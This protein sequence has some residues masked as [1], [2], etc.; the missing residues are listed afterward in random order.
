MRRAAKLPDG[1]FYCLNCFKAA[2]PS[3]R[4]KPGTIKFCSPACRKEFWRY[5]GVSVHRLRIHVQGWIREALPEILAPLLEAE[6]RRLIPELV[7]E[8]KKK[9]L[10]LGSEQQ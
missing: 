6:L 2:P 5:G 3:P 1:W 8:H 10:G 9:L 4:R 7:R